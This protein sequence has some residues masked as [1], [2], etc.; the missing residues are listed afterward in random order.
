[1]KPCHEPREHD[2]PCQ[3]FTFTA[4]RACFTRASGEELGDIVRPLETK[5]L[6]LMWACCVVLVPALQ[7]LWICKRWLGLG[8]T[9]GIMIA[10]RVAS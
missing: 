1:M 10:P 4:A 5:Q 2:L 9:D 6:D 3:L 8:Y 7:W